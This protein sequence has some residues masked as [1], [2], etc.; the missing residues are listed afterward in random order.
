MSDETFFIV[1]LREDGCLKPAPD[2][3]LFPSYAPARA[4]AYKLA[5]EN[6]KTFTVLKAVFEARPAQVL[7][8]Q[9]ED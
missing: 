1:A 2:P 3:R 7:G 4:V 8:V 6:C 9:L 5:E